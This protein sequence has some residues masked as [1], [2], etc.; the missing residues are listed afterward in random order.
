MPR[1]S[2]MSGGF[3][4]G[5]MKCDFYTIWNPQTNSCVGGGT[6]EFS[7]AQCMALGEA[8]CTANGNDMYCGVAQSCHSDDD[9]RYM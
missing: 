7:D 1:A 3:G 6:C 4:P 8:G 9:C 5:H 2:A